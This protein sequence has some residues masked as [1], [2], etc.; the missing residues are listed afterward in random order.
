MPRG[1]CQQ[2]SPGACLTLWEAWHTASLP[3]CTVTLSCWD[4]SRGIWPSPA[5]S[6]RPPNAPIWVPNSLVKPLPKPVAFPCR[7]ASV[8]FKSFV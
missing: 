8:L 3:T 6:L 2:G 4:G 1:C 5:P 7:Q